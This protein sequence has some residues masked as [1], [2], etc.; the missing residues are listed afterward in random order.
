MNI[1]TTF[2][3]YK[4]QKIS[5]NHSTFKIH[6]RWFSRVVHRIQRSRNAV[7]FCIMFGNIIYFIVLVYTNFGLYNYY[8]IFNRNVGVDGGWSRYHNS[9]CCRTRFVTASISFHIQRFGVQA[10]CFCVCV[11]LIHTTYNVQCVF[12]NFNVF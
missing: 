12:V 2:G 5:I 9:R 6:Y 10:V 7:I 8:I 4:M 3:H 11:F 1:F